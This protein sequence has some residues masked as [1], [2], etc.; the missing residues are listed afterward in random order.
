[1]PCG[2][3]VG[4]GRVTV[5]GALCSKD[6]EVRFVQSE[7]GG[8]CPVGFYVVLTDDADASGIESY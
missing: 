6:T 8:V 1:M 2:V 5:S 3:P 7:G 4:A